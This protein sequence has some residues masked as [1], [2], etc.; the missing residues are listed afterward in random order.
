MK[1]I[2]Y[3]MMTLMAMLLLASCSSKQSAKLVPD[4]A[5]LVMRVDLTK[6]QEKTGL[7]SGEDSDLKDWM[8][9]LIEDMRFD[10]AINDKLLAIIDDPSKTGVDLT[11]PLYLYA[12]GDF[13]DNTDAGLVGT[14]ASEANFTD[15]L[16]TLGD[17]AGLSIEEEDGVKYVEAGGEGAL[18]F[19]GDWFYIGT[20]DSKI[21]KTIKTL[22]ERADG[23]GTL[24]GNKAF[25]EMNGK[26]GL[27]Q[28][29]VIGSGLKEMSEMAE[30]EKVLPDGMK[31]KDIAGLIDLELKGN[32]AVI[33]SSML[34]LSDK[35]QKYIDDGDKVVN[36]IDAS[37]AKY[38]S[39]RALS[40][41]VNID[42]KGYLD[43][44]KDNVEKIAKN[45]GDSEFGDE[46][47]MEQG[48]LDKISEFA[49]ELDGT[50]SVDFYG[51][52]DEGEPLFNIYVGTKSNEMLNKLMAEMAEDADS[53]VADVADGDGPFMIPITKTDWQW[54]E[55]NEDYDFVEKVVGYRYAGFKNGQTYFC[56]DEDDVL[57]TP[58]KK[59]SA[60]AIK[61]KG[62]YIRFNFGC[63]K[64]YLDQM[65][66]SE[67]EV[68]KV[69]VDNFDFMELYYEGKG[70]GVFRLTTKGDKDPLGTL[71]DIIVEQF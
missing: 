16:E 70:T 9:E 6:M 43:L 28:L 5:L 47:S 60:D 21:K 27:M 18:I 56:S 23:K 67:R 42:V 20:V 55:Q 11:E 38:I 34:A 36:A 68:A 1:K 62:F 63:F 35:A 59:L 13:E 44:L 41:F 52:D 10:D 12:A 7:K 54:S 17:E 46:I 24:E 65:S 2:S 33:T 8:K 69:V 19:T 14:I 50:A 39:D 58:S 22:K 25:D 64:D 29:L 40:A 71:I 48:I 45:L 4:N 53:T 32:E 15:M 37:Q 31:L 30:L 51:I 49:K 66:G 57:K 3:V 61:G 26:D